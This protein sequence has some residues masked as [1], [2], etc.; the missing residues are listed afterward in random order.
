MYE[1]LMVGNYIF[2]VRTD[3][4]SDFLN[5]TKDG[6]PGLVEYEVVN[7]KKDGW[8]AVNIARDRYDITK[9]RIMVNFRMCN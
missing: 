6:S 1:L 7:L 5:F 4:A 2:K 8:T 9:N 3:G